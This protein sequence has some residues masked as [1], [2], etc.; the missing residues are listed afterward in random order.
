M[1]VFVI[2]GCAI[3]ILPTPPNDFWWHLKIGE[4]IFQTR[5][6]PD[7]NIFAWSIPVDASFTYGAWLAE[8]L[9]YGLYRVGGFDLV[10]F[11]RNI[12]VLFAF[13]L[14][15]YEISKRTG[16]S[17]L[18]A[19]AVFLAGFMSVNNLILRTQVWAFLPFVIFY[20]LLSRHAAGKIHSK[21]Q[22]L[23]APVMVFW[24]NAHGTFILG[25]VLTWSAFGVLTL[26]QFSQHRFKLSEYRLAGLFFPA[27]LITAAVF[28]NPQTTGIIQYVQGMMTDPSSQ[29]LIV[30]WQTPE[31]GNIAGFFFYSSILLLLLLFAFT[32]Y[33]P[34]LL[35]MIW[36]VLFLYLAW[37]G[38]RYV[39]WYGL[40]AMPVLAEGLSTIIKSRIT[41]KRL[42]N[43]GLVVIFAI[44]LLLV[45]PWLIERVPLSDSYWDIVHKNIPE[46]VLI[47][48]GTPVG[49]VE[50]LKTNPGGRLFNEMGYGSYLIWAM[51]ELGVFIDPRVELYP[52]DQ[53]LDYIRIG[54]GVRYNELLDKYGADRLLID[55]KLQN[56]LVI[57]LEDDRLWELEYQNE[58]S[59]IWVKR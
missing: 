36:I 30:E 37:S 7:S 53:W 12:L 45:Q 32:S 22:Y 5:T 35:S 25:L 23:L 16:S 1:G 19:L 46:G 2:F 8:L 9:F 58:Y 42:I 27:L 24:V 13:L 34:N 14:L 29:L 17:Q 39:V 48:T 49:A 57:Q 47:N 52:Y 31:I 15:G 59:Q 51:P 38:V 21:Y 28:I 44:P 43:T 33:R 26:Q 40:V 50:Y 3:S 11:M 20:I 18:A 10:V 56:E 54:R 4:L 55:K 41:E 6:I